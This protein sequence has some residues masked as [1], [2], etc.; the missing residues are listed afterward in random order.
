MKPIPKFL[1]EFGP[2]LAFFIGNWKGGVFWGTG[3][4]MAATAVALIVSWVL[5][6]KIAKFPLFSAIFVGIFGGLTIY[7]HDDTFIKVKVTLINL[8]FG[9]TLLGGLYFGKTFLKTVMGEAVNLPQEAWRTLTLRWG[10]FFMIIAGLNELIWRN[11]STDMWINF[12]V[13]GMLG[14][15]LVFALANAPFMAKHMIEEDTSS[16]QKPPA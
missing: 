13:F 10:V 5:T 16:P 2:L 15:T 6:K 3:I 8:F 1:V 11:V 4:F 12:K 9:V 14:L 7:L